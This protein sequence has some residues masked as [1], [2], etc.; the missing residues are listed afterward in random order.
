VLLLPF[1][2]FP[3][4]FSQLTGYVSSFPLSGAVFSRLLIFAGLP[5]F[6]LSTASLMLQS[7]LY[8]SDFPEQENPYVLYSASNLGSL[9]GLLTYPVFFE[10]FF[11]LTQQ[12]YIWWAGYTVFVILHMLCMPFTQGRNE[13]K[14]EAFS[15]DT[16]DLKR[17]LACFLL[18]LAGS[19][20]L[21]A[22]T[23]VITF[24]IA[25]VTFLW[26]IPLS[27][28]LLTFILV[29]KRRPW[30]PHWA[31]TLFN[32]AVPIG[33]ILYLASALRIGF[34]L[35]ITL[36]FQ[37]AILFIICLNCHGSLSGLKPSG[38]GMTVF[39]LAIAAGGFVGSFLVGI[40]VPQ[41]NT[42]FV[43]YPSSF[44]IAVLSLGLAGKYFKQRVSMK[45]GSSAVLGSMTVIISLILFPWAAN[46]FFNFSS[47]MKNVNKQ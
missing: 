32:W 33:V 22:V 15:W 2:V 27:I 44:L 6:V 4:R 36:L 38:R 1:L 10:P 5:F 47:Q 14:I 16:K 35:V 17:T 12:G 20:T 41:W 23:N 37:L 31:K 34:P 29:F 11:T 45:I 19:F 9:L 7:W 26:A 39:Y 30:Y 40:V 21:L 18:S 46:H 28:Y 13:P 42:F 24:D 8:I 3:Y 25:S 43:E